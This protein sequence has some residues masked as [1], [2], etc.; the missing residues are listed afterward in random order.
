MSIELRKS[1]EQFPT[2]QSAAFKNGRTTPGIFPSL[3]IVTYRF[4]KPSIPKR[5]CLTWFSTP[6]HAHAHSRS[7]EQSEWTVPQA[8]C[9]LIPI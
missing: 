7:I 9:S 4:I 5:T 6:P 3:D 2:L 8:R 1:D